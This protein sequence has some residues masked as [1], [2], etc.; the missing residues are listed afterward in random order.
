MEISKLF[1]PFQILREI[2]KY[3]CEGNSM[4]GEV[5]KFWNEILAKMQNRFPIF[6]PEA[7]D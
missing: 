3:I 6:K 7:N 2:D 5:K 4:N 1:L